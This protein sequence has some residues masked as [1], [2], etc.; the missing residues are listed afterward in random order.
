MH[1][2]KKPNGVRKESER[3]RRRD[4]ARERKRDEWVGVKVQ[5]KGSGIKTKG[6]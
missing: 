4:R 6:G 3:R 2:R 1:N 5:R